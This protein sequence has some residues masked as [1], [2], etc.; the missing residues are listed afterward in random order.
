MQRR[1]AGLIVM[2][3]LLLAAACNS[4]SA[5]PDAAATSTIDLRE[6]LIDAGVTIVDDLTGAEVDGLQ[7]WSWQLDNMEREL[8]RGGGFLGGEIDDI[9]GSPGGMPFSYLL[10]GWIGSGV[11]ETSAA[12]AQLM[13]ERDWE[14]APT[15]AF[16]S[17]VLMMFVADAVKAAGGDVSPQASA[18]AQLAAFAQDNE[19]SVCETVASW[20]KRVLDFM[21]EGLKVDT[22]GEG[23][24]GWLGTV[25]NSALDYARGAVESLIELVTAPVVARITEALAVVGVLTMISS[26]LTPWGLEV[27]PSQATTRVAVGGEPDIKESF[28]A[29]AD[30]NI[31]FEWPEEIRGCAKIADLE[32]P[33]PS[34]ATGAP[35][36]WRTVEYPA[37]ATEEIPDIATVTSKDSVVGSDNTATLRWT[38]G[39]QDNDEGETKRGSFS[40]T[41]VVTSDEA[42]KLK[43]LIVGLIKGK[44]PDSTPF[45]TD[46]ENYFES[47]IAPIL[48]K[49]VEFSQARG[50]ASSTVLYNFVDP[51]AEPEVAVLNPQT[52]CLGNEGLQLMVVYPDGELDDQVEDSMDYLVRVDGVPAELAADAQVRVTVEISRLAVSWVSDPVPLVSGRRLDGDSWMFEGSAPV[53]ALAVSDLIEVF[54]AVDVADGDTVRGAAQFFAHYESDLETAE[55][56][57]EEE[58]GRCFEPEVAVLNPQTGC[59]GNEGLQLMVVYP[60]GEL[61]DQVEDSMDYLVRVDG[62]PAE[63]AADAQVRVTVE[64]SR[65]AVSWVSD[66][67]PLVSG[68][69]LDG[70]SWM[71]EGSAPVGALAVSDLIE[72]FAAVDVADGDT[73]RGAAQF[74][75]HYESDLETAER[76]AEEERDDCSTPEA[77]PTGDDDLATQSGFMLLEQRF[78]FLLQVRQGDNEKFEEISVSSFE[79]DTTRQSTVTR[80]GDEFPIAPLGYDGYVDTLSAKRGRAYALLGMEF[81]TSEPTSSEIA[82]SA[83]FVRTLTGSSVLEGSK[84]NLSLA[85]A[86]AGIL[87]TFTGEPL[88][89]RMVW[90]CGLEIRL[91]DIQDLENPTDIFFNRWDPP[92]TVDAPL[93]DDHVI[94]DDKI[95]RECSEIVPSFEGTLQ[96]DRVYQLVLDFGYFA[97]RYANDGKVWVQGEVI[98]ETGK[99][100]IHETNT[101]AL[102]LTGD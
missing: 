75:A 5:G 87:F 88:N 32:L 68:R 33:D 97:D 3:F 92:V 51:F 34:S 42:V 63:L 24:L 1:Q 2:A 14:Q 13:S 84:D 101:F 99:Y 85:Y 16:P 7:L 41:A 94:S 76:V 40:A 18:S 44:I 35:I 23:F 39:R 89:V 47:L 37:L 22:D 36:E 72:V 93:T 96:P 6:V 69:R 98:S 12:A 25:W 79:V 80:G 11:S 77:D 83:D 21:F 54:A 53:G 52:G 9:A 27:R 91:A 60:D 38:T 28:V 10:A 70:D 71:F 95:T 49:L 86:S 29:V 64:I 43:S 62:V 78:N 4:D 46:I 82:M 45:A 66:P 15:I 57:A 56:V 58:R 48:D 20:V 19:S 26:L 81:F 8:S 90:D 100:D 50:D 59:L 65:L 30:T 73:V 31:D 102:I 17:A 74:F 55:R 67:V 61:D